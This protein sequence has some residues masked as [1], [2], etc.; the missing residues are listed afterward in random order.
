MVV[1]CGFEEKKRDFSRNTEIFFK[2][3]FLNFYLENSY[4]LISKK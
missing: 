3:T 1:G 4:Y 2:Q